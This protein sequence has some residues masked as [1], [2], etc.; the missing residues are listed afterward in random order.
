MAALLFFSRPALASTINFSFTLPASERTSAGVYTADSTSTLV[1]TLWSGVAQSAGAQ[2][3]TWDG[4][5]DD[6]TAAPAGSYAV[7]VL[8]NNVQYN[9]QGVIGNTSSAFTTLN[10]GIYRGLH[11]LNDMAFSTISSQAFAMLGYNEGQTNVLTFST[12]AVQTPSIVMQPDFYTIWSLGATDGTR[13][14]LA[15]TGDQNYLGFDTHNSCFVHSFNMNSSSATF[16]SGQVVAPSGGPSWPSGIDVYQ[17]IISSHDPSFV[18]AHEATGLA[19]QQTSNVLAVAHGG[20]NLVNLYDKTSGAFLG[21]I[22]VPNPGRIAFAPNGDLWVVTNTSVDRFAGVTLGSTSVP[23]TA[24]SGFLAPMAVTVN[25][26]TGDVLVADGDLSQQVKAFSS[27]GSPLWTLGQAG[28]YSSANGPAV[29]TNKFQFA[30]V[31]GFNSP[32]STGTFLAS[33]ADG[34][35]W[36]GDGGNQRA[37]HFSAAQI[38]LGQIGFLTA[39]YAVYADP[40]NP[41]RVFS[42]GYLEYRLD[43]T[44]T[45]SPGDPDPTFGGNGSWKL[46]NNWSAGYMPD[47]HTTYAGF[48]NVTTLTSG[49]VSRTFAELYQNGVNHGYFVI[50]E[51]PASGPMRIA[52]SGAVTPATQA[53]WL[54]PNGDLFNSTYSASTE[55]IT[56][57]RFTGFDGS[58]NPLWSAASVLATAPAASGDPFSVYGYQTAWNRP[59]PTFPITASNDIISF[60]PLQ[61]TTAYRDYHLGAI[62]VG[63]STYHFKTS[64]AAAITYPDGIGTYPTQASPGG[65]NGTQVWAIG[66]NIVW[67][68][69]G[70]YANFSNQFAHYYDDGLFLGQFGQNLEANGAGAA[71]AGFAGN[72]GATSMV[73]GTD[74]NLYVFTS[75]ES[76]HAGVHVWKI[77]GLGTIGELKGTGTLGQGSIL[78]LTLVVPPKSPVGLRFQ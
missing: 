23:A 44:Q 51:L 30:S 45:L 73:T 22:S 9:W 20:L 18:N 4:N 52:Y 70:Q 17:E 78:P 25:P 29:T 71:I 77:S 5:L 41:T 8:Y 38:Y 46:V 59:T 32:L 56:V 53:T 2:N 35:F 65:H 1:R 27:A 67:N 74:G 62:P 60:N 61:G 54:S 50:V 13:L 12:N 26:L 68:Y 69:D 19:V 76:V 40:N 66:H 43:Y 21:N 7:K 75:D 34:S 57:Q 31:A 28:G 36:L 72:Y 42:Q 37:L 14:Y 10:G 49:G 15:D 48:S 16:T 64:T 3:A 24:I 6:G 39:N 47:F 58:G 55:T 33:Q 11:G 63:G